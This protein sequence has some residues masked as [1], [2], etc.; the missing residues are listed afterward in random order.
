MI[1]HSICLDSAFKFGP[2]N[3]EESNYFLLVQLSLELP[4]QSKG[5]TL[6]LGDLLDQE[7]LS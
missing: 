5:R 4:G 6:H 7:A 1:S 2:K 3:K